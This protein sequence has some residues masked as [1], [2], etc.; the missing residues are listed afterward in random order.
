[1]MNFGDGLRERIAG[2]AGIAGFEDESTAL[3]AGRLDSVPSIAGAA[4]SSIELS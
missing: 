3:D 4:G 2:A 1:M